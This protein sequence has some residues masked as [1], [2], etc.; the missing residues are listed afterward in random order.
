VMTVRVS[1]V[2]VVSVSVPVVRVMMVRV[3]VVAVV[4]VSV[5]VVWVRAV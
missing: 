3:S 5:P 4:S 2:A 1:V